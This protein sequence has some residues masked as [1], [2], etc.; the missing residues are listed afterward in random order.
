VRLK[1]LQAL[2]MDRPDIH[3]GTSRQLAQRLTATRDNPI[4]QLRG[5][6]VGSAGQETGFE[7]IN[8]D[9]LEADFGLA[10]LKV[11]SGA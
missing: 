9:V 3:H 7:E 10:S 1:Q 8:G 2:S 6:L 4:L 11:Y 5:C